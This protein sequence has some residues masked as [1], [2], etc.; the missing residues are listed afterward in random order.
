VL[1]VVQGSYTG[2]VSTSSTSFVTTNL[3]ASI[4][5]SSSSNKILVMVSGGDCYSQVTNKVMR[6]TI[7]RNNSTNLATGGA[8][9]CFGNGYNSAGGITAVH[10]YSYL[11]SPA[12]TSST[13]YT[14]YMSAET[15]G[16]ANYNQ[17]GTTS[18][19]LLME[20]SA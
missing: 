12:T 16:L 19:I 8:I 7:Y 2:Q 15:S 1:Q 11:D 17:N 9:P 3:T 13:A 4:T 10:S 20:I 14:V 6:T 18:Y 5:P